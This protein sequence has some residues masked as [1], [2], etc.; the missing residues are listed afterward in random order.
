MERIVLNVLV[1][2]IKEEEEKEENN[3]II[4]N[5]IQKLEEKENELSKE[6]Q[7]LYDAGLKGGFMT[8]NAYSAENNLNKYKLQK[9][10]YT[11]EYK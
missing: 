3:K 7:A 11:K 6:I 1:D 8:W 2:Y 9:D 5:F 10:A 4:H